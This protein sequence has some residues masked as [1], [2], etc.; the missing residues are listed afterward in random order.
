MRTR[1]NITK[2]F[3]RKDY[4][5]EGKNLCF[6]RIHPYFIQAGSNKPGTTVKVRLKHQGKG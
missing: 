3:T 5:S 1:F 2:N 6:M 4:S